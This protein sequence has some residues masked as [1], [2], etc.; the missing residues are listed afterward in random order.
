MK[1][2]LKCWKDLRRFTE[3]HYLH[4]PTKRA[5]KEWAR[6]VEDNKRKF[7]MRIETIVDC[8]HE[9]GQRP[10]LTWSMHFYIRT[11]CW[12]Q[13]KKK[14]TVGMRRIRYISGSGFGMNNMKLKWYIAIQSFGNWYIFARNAFATAYRMP[15]KCFCSGLGMIVC[16][17]MDRTQLK[18]RG[19]NW[20]IYVAR[21]HAVGHSFLFASN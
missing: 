16:L 14:Q 11:K 9:C 10:V 19:K 3:T 18:A 17:E 4:I 7:Q 2:I 8:V 13:C 12:T 15:V 21:P 20:I 6:I 5:P 1:D